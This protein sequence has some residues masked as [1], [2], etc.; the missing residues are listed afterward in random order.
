MVKEQQGKFLLCSSVDDYGGKSET[1]PY[2]RIGSRAYN[3]S[4]S[5]ADALA[6]PGDEAPD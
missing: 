3:L 2:L 4:V 1:R 6:T 5:L